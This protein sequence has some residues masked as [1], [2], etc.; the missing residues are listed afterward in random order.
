[1]RAPRMCANHW[2]VSLE[3]ISKGAPRVKQKPCFAPADPY[4][5][6]YAIGRL[7]QLLERG[8]VVPPASTETRLLL[9]DAI[10]RINALMD[11]TG[12]EE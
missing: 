2:Q 8:P 6:R 1:M 7:E 3:P 12:S 10:G 5:L 11:G 9:R 4:A